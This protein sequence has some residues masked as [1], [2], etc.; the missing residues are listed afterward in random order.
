MKAAPVETDTGALLADRERILTPERAT[1][2]AMAEVVH[3]LV[4]HFEWSGPVGVAFPA[5]IRHGVVATAAN[6]D[7]SWIGTD[8]AEVFSEASGSRVTVV[9]DA[10]AAGSA[11]LRFG[12]GRGR[13]GTVVM[14]TLGTGIGTALF[15]G[16]KL[17]PNTELGHLM[18][19]GKTAEA[20]AAE[21]VRERKGLSWKEWA[22]RLEEFF[23]E[24]ER[25]LWPDL[26]VIGGGV[27]KK[28]EKFI[29]RLGLRAD[30]VPAEMRN[31][32]G[33]VGAAL[34]AL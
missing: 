4:E 18:I 29:P 27:S 1:P 19:R 6:I 13:D 34:A 28:S 8:A 26:F 5:V 10:D 7:E 15:T 22:E 2:D 25:L 20:R 33:I 17:V 30:V 24:L 9:N 32:A 12:A 14:V 16:G 3:R 11:E 31:E 21:S 23:T